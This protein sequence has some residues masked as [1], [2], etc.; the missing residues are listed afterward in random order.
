MT[1]PVD[2]RVVEALRQMQN[3]IVEL[4]RRVAALESHGHSPTRRIHPDVITKPTWKPND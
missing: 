4:A 2:P 1:D 3:A